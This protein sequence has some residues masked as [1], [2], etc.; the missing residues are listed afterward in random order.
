MP[1]RVEILHPKDR[2]VPS[3]VVAKSVILGLES[4]VE[5]LKEAGAYSRVKDGK[6]RLSARQH[7]LGVR[8]TGIEPEEGKFRDFEGR[9]YIDN[10]E[11]RQ[12]ET[13]R[14]ALAR[15]LRVLPAR[16]SDMR[17][18]IPYRSDYEAVRMQV[19]SHDEEE[20]GS[21]VVLDAWRLPATRLSEML[22]SDDRDMAA[23]AEL[24]RDIFSRRNEA[25]IP[26]A[27]E[28]VRHWVLGRPDEVIHSSEQVWINKVMSRIDLA[29]QSQVAWELQP[30]QY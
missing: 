11:L 28:N 26:V 15:V 23:Y 24:H 18:A 6:L 3:V 10:V 14:I 5:T 30:A 8:D 1:T 7:L 20:I 21:R 19:N 4:A 29:V 22:M 12:S 13:G 2:R 25:G 9:G 16:I 17:H 27:A